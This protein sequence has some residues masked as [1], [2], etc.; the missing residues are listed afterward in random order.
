[1][2]QGKRKGLVFHLPENCLPENCSCPDSET[3]AP[4]Y[5]KALAGLDDLE[6]PY[7]LQALDHDTVLERIEADDWFHIVAHG[8]SPHAR[9]LMAGVAYLYPYWHVDAQGIRAFSSIG[10][11]KF[12]AGQIDG[13]QAREFLKSLRRKWVEPRKSRYE[14]QVKPAKH[15]PDDAVAVFLQSEKY[16]SLAETCHMDCWQ[17]IEACL[18][19]ERG[20]IVVKPHPLDL[21]EDTFE[22]LMGLEDAHPNLHVS[23]DNIHDI[24]ACAKRVVTINSAVGVEAYLHRK[25][26]ILCGQADFHHIADVARSPQELTALL[27]QE[28]AGRVYAKYLY[29]YFE[30][31][32]V[33][34]GRGSVARQILR[35]IKA[36][37][38]SFD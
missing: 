17:M 15:L 34:A 7:K 9:A 36:T 18:A 4:F 28:P 11:K 14:Q 29:W 6:V 33:N 24:L 25:P 35:K 20:P 22:R 37:G 13:D 10:E 8:R 21:D 23:L 19:A 1:M 32:C 16:R 3:M 2:G 26:V 38:Y 27:R 31:N 30:R 12:R 5:Q